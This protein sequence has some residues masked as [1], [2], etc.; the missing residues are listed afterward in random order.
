MFYPGAGAA[1]S[2]PFI[3]QT[4][5]FLGGFFSLQISTPIFRQSSPIPYDASMPQVYLYIYLYISMCL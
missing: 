5:A 3:I 1:I 2:G 4:P